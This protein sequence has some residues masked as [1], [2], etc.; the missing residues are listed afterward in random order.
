MGTFFSFLSVQT[1]SIMSHEAIFCLKISIPV[2]HQMYG[3]FEPVMFDVI[4]VRFA[5][6]VL[7]IDNKKSLFT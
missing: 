3:T 2:D 5:K 4:D 7:F 6:V 1:V